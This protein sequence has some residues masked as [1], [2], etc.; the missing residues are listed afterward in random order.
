M[1]LA[2][3]H[4]AMVAREPGDQFYAWECADCGHAYAE[5]DIC[6]TT[7]RLHRPDLASA[8]IT[9]DGGESYVDVTCLDCGRSGCLGML[10]DL[11]KDIA[12]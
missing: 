2:C 11:L 12:W 5:D 10:S 7:H 9:S 4:S 1:A 3:Q 6:P 8:H